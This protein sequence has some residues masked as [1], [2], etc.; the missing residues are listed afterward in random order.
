MELVEGFVLVHIRLEFMTKLLA[1]GV[2][3]TILWEVG[4]H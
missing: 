1:F 3:L 4:V 2:L